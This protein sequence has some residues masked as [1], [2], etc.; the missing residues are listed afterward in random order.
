MVVLML[1]TGYS[2]LSGYIMLITLGIS[3]KAINL[4]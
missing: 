4:R 2:E 1:N 3:A